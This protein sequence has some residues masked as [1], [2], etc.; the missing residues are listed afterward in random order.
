MWAQ[1]SQQT[2]KAPTPK[3]GQARWVAS[4]VTWRACNDAREEK[5][6]MQEGPLTQEEGSPAKNNRQPQKEDRHVVQ[7]RARPRM[8]RSGWP[9]TEKVTLASTR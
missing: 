2:S 3:T 9:T 4:R 5:R 1:A 6:T 8:A 7:E